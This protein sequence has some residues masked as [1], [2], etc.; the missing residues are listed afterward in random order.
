[1]MQ[2]CIKEDTSDCNVG[3]D[4][5]YAYTKNPSGTN[6]FGSA[7]NKIVLYIF[8]KDNLYVGNIVVQG[9]PLTNDYVQNVSLPEAGV[10]TF[11]AWCAGSGSGD[12]EIVQKTAGGFDKNFIVGTTKLSDMRMRVV[13]AKHGTIDTEINDLFFGSQ[14][15]VEVSAG[16]AYTPVKIDL[17]KNTNTINLS[18]SG[19]APEQTARTASANYEVT[20]STMGGVYNF[21]N[22]V[23]KSSSSEYTYKQYRFQADGETLTHS[24]K[25]LRL[26]TW[27][28]MM[29][30]ITETK[31][32][33]VILAPTNTVAMIMQNP[34]YTTQDDLDR[35]DTYNIFIKKDV[36]V[37]ITVNGWE[38]I[39]TDIEIK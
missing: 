27:R 35:E 10:Y 1:M 11:V 23:D 8:D 36:D 31:S 9:S 6:Q 25:T 21:D 5:T 33:D 24:L 12:Y 29:L 15:K 20:I 39:D 17:I 2:S 4:V 30:S 34:S 22:T 28:E 13:E 3:V 14:H 26:L 16:S 37:T 32:G 7:V 38:I 18:M 19:F